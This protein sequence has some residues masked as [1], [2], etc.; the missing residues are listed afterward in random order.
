MKINY[1]IDGE[2]LTSTQYA[3]I[4]T[5]I[6]EYFIKKYKSLTI[7]G[8]VGNQ[9]YAQI[10]YLAIDFRVN[11]KFDP[12]HFI[13]TLSVN[14]P[15]TDFYLY[16]TAKSRY[17]LLVALDQ[18]YDLNKLK[19]LKAQ[20]NLKTMLV[21]I[22]GDTGNVSQKQEL[23]A[24]L[25]LDQM[26]QIGYQF[27]ET[28]NKHQSLP[29]NDQPVT[30]KEQSELANQLKQY[31]DETKNTLTYGKSLDRLLISVK[32]TDLK[33]RDEILNLIQKY[34][35]ID[36]HQ[37]I[38]QLPVDRQVPDLNH[39]YIMPQDQ[40]QLSLGK[41]LIK[42]TG[43][44]PD[45]DMDLDQV[46]YL[47]ERTFMWGIDG[48]CDS[49]IEGLLIFDPH[50]GYWVNN[51]ELLINLVDTVRP[52][53][54]RMDIQK[55]H[56]QLSTNA[57][58]H[59]LFIYPYT[60][61]RYLLFNNCVLDV[62][63]KEQL[64]LD[65]DFVKELHF[66]ERT[67]INI[68]YNPD[69][70]C[71]VI[72]K[73]RAA[74]EGDWTLDDFL[75]AY[76]NNDPKL[77]QY[78]L[79]CLS[80]S[81][82]SG[83]N[84]GVTIDIKGSSGWGK[85]TLSEPLKQL[86]KYSTV[87]NFRRLN[88]SFPFSGYNLESGLIWFD[89]CNSDCNE[90][91]PAGT[92]L[93]DSLCNNQVRFE[94][95]NKNDVV[96]YDPPTVYV[97]GTALIRANDVMTGPARRTL[98]IELPASVDAIPQQN[99]RKNIK[100]GEPLSLRDQFFNL[101]IMDDLHRTDV[102]QY[103]INQL[104]DAY[105]KTVDPRIMSDLKIN[106]AN[107]NLTKMLDIPPI[108]NQWRKDFVLASNDISEWFIEGV[109]SNL[110][111]SNKDGG[112]YLHNDVMY[113]L[114]TEYYRQHNPTDRGLR[115]IIDKKKFD[116]LMNQSLTENDLIYEEAGSRYN[117][118]HRPRKRVNTFKGMHFDISN[119]QDTFP[120]P[121]GLKNLNNLPAPFNKLT[122]GW[123]LVKP[124]PTYAKTFDGEPTSTEVIPDEGSANEP[125]VS[126]NPFSQAKQDMH[127]NEEF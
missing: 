18:G 86:H 121:E 60:G 71:P 16:V 10:G 99:V 74:D 94:T 95:K 51:D 47:L 48:N 122:D 42:N 83:H 7:N 63:N 115:H 114:Y 124:S 34:T 109:K 17:R 6:E 97:D 44:N 123:Y 26:H 28:S 30:R 89:E 31:L 98:P 39:F 78:F 22:L 40:R 107:H 12:E 111:F 112:T 90:L 27:W 108:V 125:S 46:V 55:I 64:S 66:T 9:N 93:Y 120:M 5:L 52:L 84:F 73:H 14:M 45:P 68:D 85:T 72:P 2:N 102:L 77:K 70:E 118:Y 59:Q 56:D 100:T 116:G 65:S 91:S 101:M 127:R 104:I 57:R 1:T 23:G 29:L 32:Q 43:V 105:R 33:D 126:T 103:F 106:L 67:H 87:I 76:S 49:S 20:D 4:G 92:A 21:N 82:F 8:I 13:Q 50:V 54:S 62:L 15:A 119:Y 113:M 110:N 35:D 69:I 80:L 37:R 61:S 75:D 81:L 53:S 96:L 25:V 41:F 36:V 24:Q 19:S 58:N 79:F 11:K 117:K 38:T 3:N 88:E